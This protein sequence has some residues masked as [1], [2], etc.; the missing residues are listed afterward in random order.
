MKS[1]LSLFVLIFAL[2][3]ELYVPFTE[4]QKKTTEPSI[5]N[6]TTITTTRRT[7]R[8][9]TT[10]AR[11][12]F[13]GVDYNEF[14]EKHTRGLNLDCSTRYVKCYLYTPLHWEVC[15][16][17]NIS[18][19]YNDVY[20]TCQIDFMNCRVMRFKRIPKIAYHYNYKSFQGY[21]HKCKISRGFPNLI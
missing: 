14:L 15:M 2:I 16:F 6:D 13:D 9:R 21:G 17:D 20:S 10:R 5:D 8:T 12:T 4:A 1:S 7:R 3:Y 18:N 19:E 11:Y